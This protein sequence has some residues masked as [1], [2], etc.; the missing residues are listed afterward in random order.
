MRELNVVTFNLLTQ[1]CVS[2][3]SCPLARSA[4]IN[5]YNRWKL[6]KLTIL[7][8]IFNRSI[9]CLQEVSNKWAEKLIKFFL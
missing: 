5:E 8:W 2:K 7:N 4:D 6:T 1:S 9:I 3:E